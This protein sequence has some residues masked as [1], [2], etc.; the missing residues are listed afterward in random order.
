MI[1]ITA[2]KIASGTKIVPLKK[3]LRIRQEVAAVEGSIIAVRLHGTKNVYNEI[4]D[5]N[6][7]MVPL[8]D[9]DIVVGVLGH[10]N[11]LHG[12][13]GYI[14]ETVSVGDR[15][16]ILNLGGV[17]GKCTSNNPD[18]GKPFE[19]EVLG[20]V[21]VFPTFEDRVGVPAHTK[22]N[23]LPELDISQQKSVPVVFVAG[24]CMNSGKTAAACQLVKDLSSRGYQVGACKLTGVSLLKDVLRMQDYGAKWGLSFVDAGVV[25]TSAKTSIQTARTVIA[26]LIQRG[27]EVV[28]AELGDGILGEYGVQG[29]LAD[30]KVM[31]LKAAL[32][33][34]ANDP[35]GVWG[36]L[37]ILDEE[38]GLSVD[39]VSGPITDNAVGTTFVEKTF[40]VSA[41]NAR[42]QSQALGERVTL[43]LKERDFLA[44]KPVT[45]T[46]GLLAQG[47]LGV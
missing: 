7:R 23:A 36:G 15:L 11:A 4:E 14:P 18:V 33:L 34:C 32:V 20:S 10:R 45:A 22:M 6:G 25:T 28:V 3:D 30:D 46:N 13:A 31:S 35:V 16:N 19:A 17:I 40:S 24:T 1:R 21:L 5:C 8:H 2:D 43:L 27:A 42:T 41:I 29:I 44:D 39:V 47:E 26:N 12:Y 9:G 37:K 38:Y